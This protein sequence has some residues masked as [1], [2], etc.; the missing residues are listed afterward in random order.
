MKT[1]EIGQRV[2]VVKIELVGD[3]W[4]VGEKGVV[5]R[6]NYSD[7]QVRLD[8][9]LPELAPDDDRLYWFTTNELEAIDNDESR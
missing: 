3:P 9:S 1:F 7:V 6:Q 8:E 4:F 2:K 5:V